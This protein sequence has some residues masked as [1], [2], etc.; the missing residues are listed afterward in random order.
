MIVDV[1]DISI[2]Y[3]V[4]DFRDIGLKDFVVHKLKRDFHVQEFWAVKNV[5]FTLE[6]GDFLG[7]I[8]TNG[9]GKSTLLKTISGIMRPSKG[10]YC[11]NGKISALLELGTGFDPDLTLRE[12]IFLRGALLGYTKQFMVEKCE[13][14]LEF[15]ELKEY[16]GRKY[17]QLSSGMK[18]RLAFSIACFVNPDI[19]ILD[20]VL[21]VGD[22]SFR[23]KSEKKMFEI[24]KGGATTLFV[25]HSTPQV[26]R[27]CNK[28]L[29]LHKGEQIAFG[30]TA[31]IL[32]V[33]EKFLKDGI[34]PEKEAIA[35][36]LEKSEKT[37]VLKPKPTAPAIKFP[38]AASVVKS[39]GVI[40]KNKNGGMDLETTKIGV[41][42]CCVISDLF[43]YTFSE[44]YDICARIGRNPITTLV[45]DSTDQAGPFLD[46]AATNYNK[47]MINLMFENNV[48]EQILN[49]HA[50]YLVLDFSEERLVQY[51]I[52]YEDKKFRVMDF[53][54]SAK[55]NWFQQAKEKL[56]GEN[57]L[58]PGGTVREIPAREI[59]FAEI[60]A[61]YREFAK[62][63]V[64]SDANP[65]GYAP[66]QIIVVESYLV[67]RFI[68]EEGKFQKFHP[69]WKVAE[70]NAFL[71]PIYELFYQLVP[72]C[73][74]VKMPQHA[75]A[76]MHHIW[77]AHPLHY[78]DATYRYFSAAFDIITGHNKFLS[79]PDKLWK[80][81][82]LE[83][84]IAVNLIESASGQEIAM[85]KKRLTD[86]E[87]QIAE[88]QKIT[89]Q[90]QE[91][92]E[93]LLDEVSR[94]GKK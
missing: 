19:L 21:S 39:Q 44:R 56:V 12:N 80:Q 38:A 74:V 64:K 66:E 73:H 25:S 22:G 69:N 37:V 76:N 82:S 63:I 10:T 8:G 33:Y 75:F 18:S 26:R 46:F 65:D 41:C 43:K 23:A 2:R 13:E 59:P 45:G 27:L 49:C 36:L 55:G 17:K 93:M 15:S 42:G 31:V 87:A 53:W 35:A 83:N 14:I 89:S 54:V 71:K 40:Q 61:A 3:I 34:L 91:M 32:P 11:T 90:Q 30:P 48:V 7:I 88:L 92:I 20:E 16:E 72:G 68:N 78:S 60:E 29:W 86:A 85:L 94:K 84:R 1:K 4:G 77:G 58:F 24:I 51:E 50:D 81:Q 5:S 28:V 52:M 9:A 62:R 6:E 79:T 47:R 67:D 70:T 57:G